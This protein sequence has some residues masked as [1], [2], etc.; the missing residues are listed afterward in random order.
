MNAPDLSIETMKQAK[1]AVKRG[2]FVELPS[3][4]APGVNGAAQRSLTA[5]QRSRLRF[6]LNPTHES[7]DHFFQAGGTEES[8]DDEEALL[9]DLLRFLPCA[10][11]QDHAAAVRFHL[12]ALAV[13]MVRERVLE[14]LDG[15]L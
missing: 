2:E 12:L 1:E 11:P 5:L 13:A 6:V 9:T 7:Y 8:A 4:H 3:P 14:V 10:L 15:G